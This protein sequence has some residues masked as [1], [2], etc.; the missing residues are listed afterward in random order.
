MR[1]T[2]FA[3]PSL[4]FALAL[5]AL[6]RPLAAQ[7]RGFSH[8]DTLRGSNDPER[9]WWDLTYYDLQLRVNPADSTVGGANTVRYRVLSQAREL[10]LDL[11]TPMQL[12]SVVQDGVKQSLRRD[13]NAYF[14]RL[15]SAQSVGSTRALTAYWHGRPR[16]AKNPP[17]DG[18][19]TWT[20]DPD[21]KPWIATSDQG[22]GA[23]VFW[24]DKDQQADEPDSMR[25]RVTVPSS[26]VEV[27][28]GRLGGST[29]NADGTT[30]YEWDVHDPINNYGVT[31]NAGSYVHFGDRM[32][33]ESGPLDLDYWVLGAHLEDAKRQF[34]Q[35]KPMIACYEHW[36]GPYPWYA[37]GYKLVESPYLGMEH[38]SA[39]AYGNRFKNGYLGSDL[40]GTGIGLSFDYI[41]V[42][43]SAHEWWGNSI[44]SKDIA[45]MWVHEAFAMYAEGLFVECTQGK[46]AELKYLVGVRSRIANDG[47]IV[48]RYGVNDEG[49]GDMY[50]KGANVLHT[51]RQLARD[52][53]QWR[54]TLRGIQATYRHQTVTGAQIEAALSKGV[55]RDLSKVFQQ[56]FER[57][58]PPTLE[59]APAADGIRY[60][61][62]ADVPGFDLPVRVAV[63][64]KTQMI[65]PAT[66][67]W[68]TL[69][70][71]PNA[72]LTVDPNFYVDVEKVKDAR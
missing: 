35:V 36:F 61:W 65:E 40:S 4:L 70:A 9:A 45:D 71:S 58:K 11:Q 52:D 33:G 69:A 55:G 20:K 53:E 34:A 24:P 72:E 2:R 1:R 16:V 5:V 19:F 59:W 23:S 15:S 57:A 31:I 66:D 48:G 63:G 7:G 49:S 13:G 28:N 68:K 26:M 10:Q 38:Q 62:R 17:W 32:E 47:P 51:I 12:D 39:V 3:R 43:E 6:P 22:L 37:D 46:E 56:Y 21:G 64:G 27:S 60:R 41:I 30:T 67:A 50:F 8:A 14:V 44:T 42:H 54:Q 25:I 29:T 18:G